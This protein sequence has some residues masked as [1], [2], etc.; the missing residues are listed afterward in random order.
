MLMQVGHAHV[1]ATSHNNFKPIE[2]SSRSGSS[3]SGLTM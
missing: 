2:Y 3:S 1:S